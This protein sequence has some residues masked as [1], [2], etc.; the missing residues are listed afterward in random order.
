MTGTHFWN[1]SLEGFDI[2]LKIFN[3]CNIAPRSISSNNDVFLTLLSYSNAKLS[4]I[5]PNKL[6]PYQVVRNNYTDYTYEYF[7]ASYLCK[8]TCTLLATWVIEIVT[9]IIDFTIP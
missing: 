1:C 5:F 6:K 7:S 4:T 3:T 2:I 9:W 8:M